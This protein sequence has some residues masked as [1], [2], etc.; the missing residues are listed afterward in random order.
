MKKLMILAVLSLLVKLVAAQNAGSLVGTWWN[1]EK[2]SKIE[3][4]EKD[5][6]FTG[7][8]VYLVPEKYVNGQP[9]KD[10]KNPDHKLRNRSMLGLPILTGLQY[11]P[12]DKQWQ[13][14]RIYDPKSGKSYDC[15][16]WFDGSTD[17]LFIKGFVVGI[18]WLGRSTTWTRVK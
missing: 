4:V 3:I 5:G 1:E 7:K 6:K 15:F 2:T 11:T 9:P 10:E 16:A 13:N 12:A 18:K 14:G 8:I 17:R